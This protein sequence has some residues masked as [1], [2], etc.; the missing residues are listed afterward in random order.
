VIIRPVGLHDYFSSNPGAAAGFRAAL[1]K[2]VPSRSR[3]SQ[4]QNFDERRPQ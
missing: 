3:T 2:F 1:F 4:I